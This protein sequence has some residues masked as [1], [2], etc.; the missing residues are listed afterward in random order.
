VGPLLIIWTSTTGASEQLSLAAEQAANTSGA[1][2]V[3]CRRLHAAD[4]QP[5]DLLDAGGYLFITPEHLGSMAGSMKSFFDRCYYPVLDQLNGR[6]YA[7]MVSAGSD[8]AGTVRQLERIVTGWRLRKVAEPI[9][10]LTHAQ[11]AEAI[12]APK[13]L[14]QPALARARELGAALSEGIASGIW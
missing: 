10:V 9:I 3:S 2:A 1:D 5:Q 14:A 12:L 6:P 7:A 4:V 13:T 11:S 8:G